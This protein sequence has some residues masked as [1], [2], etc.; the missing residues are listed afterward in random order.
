VPISAFSVKLINE[1]VLKL[2]IAFAT[3]VLGALVIIKTLNLV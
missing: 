1:G 3:I 2:A